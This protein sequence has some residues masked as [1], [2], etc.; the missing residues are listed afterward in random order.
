M[1][2]LI[3]DVAVK[4]RFQD[5]DVGKMWGG[6]KRFCDDSFVNGIEGKWKGEKLIHNML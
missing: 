4:D 5:D 1:D 2:S 3:E 6:N